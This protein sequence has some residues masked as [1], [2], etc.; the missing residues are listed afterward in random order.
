MYFNKHQALQNKGE[1]PHPIWSSEV[2]QEQD[3]QSSLISLW[4]S[5]L[6]GVVTYSYKSFELIYTF[7]F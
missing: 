2:A 7:S 6:L 5:S 3:I 1:D 4:T